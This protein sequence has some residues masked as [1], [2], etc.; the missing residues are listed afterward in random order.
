MKVDTR[1]Y[2]GRIT[3]S[4]TVHTN[5]P[6]A[7]SRTIALEAY[8]RPLISITPATLFLEGREGE[9][10]KG[11][12]EIRAQKETPLRL[13]PLRFDLGEKVTYSLEEVE[14]GRLYRAHFSSAPGLSGTSYGQLRLRTNYPEKPGI[15]IRIRYKIGS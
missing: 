14:P 12:V 6:K 2:S 11:S 15:S 5:D 10:V 3:K 7:R 8:V 13:E 1:G 4:A 9:V